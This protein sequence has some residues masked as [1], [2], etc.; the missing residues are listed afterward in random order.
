MI[1]FADGSGLSPQN[2]VSAR[3]EV[4][5]LIYAK[6]QTW[7]ESYYDGFPTQDNGMKMKSGTMRDTKSFAGFHTSKEGKKYVFSII[8]NNYQGSG[9][10]ELQKILNVLK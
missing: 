1:N 10:S 9:S 8:I 5:A 7:F 6:K 4:Q 2:Y 3:A